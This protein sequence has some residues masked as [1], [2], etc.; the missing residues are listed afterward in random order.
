MQIRGFE[1][2]FFGILTIILATVVLMYATT[3]RG[4][5]EVTLTLILAV[6][7]LVVG[8][9]FGSLMTGI[10]FKFMDISIVPT[11]LSASISYG[12]MLIVNRFVPFQISVTSLISVQWLG[13]LVGIA[14]EC[15]FRVWLCGIGSYF[16]EWGAII[17]SSAIWSAYHIGRYG[18]GN[19]NFYPIIF[20][21]G[22]GL[23]WTY[24]TFR[25]ADGIFLSHGFWNY[26]A[27]KSSQKIVEM[28]VNAIFF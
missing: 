22:L 12:I 8:L 7:F 5:P 1:I 25:I 11:L 4:D 23:G 26:N 13:V 15:F 28:I 16:S 17:G 10:K 2:R 3:F 14:E 19:W 18:G 21:C 9:T 27:L 24:L 20:L 6:I